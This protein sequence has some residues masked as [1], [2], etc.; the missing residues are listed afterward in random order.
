MTPVKTI[1][2]KMSY[3]RTVG[4]ISDQFSTRGTPLRAVSASHDKS[5]PRTSSLRHAR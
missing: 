1:T 3:P 5:P 2:G 4:S